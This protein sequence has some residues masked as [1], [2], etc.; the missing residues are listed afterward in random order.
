MRRL[1]VKGLVR[2][3]DRVRRELSHPINPAR[4]NELRTG[5]EAEVKA[6]A[7]HLAREGMTAR[8]MPA[9][10]RRAYLFLA[11][12]D[13]DAVNVDLQEHASGPPPGSVFFSGLERN[14]KVL[15][16]RL[17]LADPAGREALLASLRKMTGEIEGLCATLQPHQIKP[18]ARALRGWLAYFAQAE[19]FER[20]CSALLLAR[21]ALNL[22]A[23]RAG[24]TVGDLPVIRFVPMSG[25]YRVRFGRTHL[26]ADLIP[27][28]ICLGEADWHELAGRIFTNARGMSVYLERI[29]Q[30]DDYRAIQA[31]LEAGGGVVE[32]SRGLHHDLASSFERVNAEYFASA[33]PRP[34]LTWSSVLTRRKLGHYDRA[35]D[36]VM[37]SSALDAPLVPGCAV[38]FIMYHE[39]LHKAQ[40]NGSSTSRRIVHDAKFQRDEKRFRLYDQAKT[41]LAKLR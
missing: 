5:V 11:G 2:Y 34:R 33:L 21:E 23:R 7:E 1:V 6:L 25:I 3:A 31:E 20:Y 38:D 10:T 39:L 18:K 28:L 26:E 16:A 27:P 19:N 22:A 35:H 24:K 29:V 13:W 9:P 8:D 30:R 12:L 17:A 14:V 32:R 15:T 40:G 37:V 41:A 36:T 4:L